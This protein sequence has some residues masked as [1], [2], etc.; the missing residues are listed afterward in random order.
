MA[1]IKPTLPTL[2]ELHHDVKEAFKNDKLNLLLNQPPHE[3]WIKE[4]PIL[5]AK[6]DKGEDVKWRYIPVDKIEFMLTRIFGM[7]QREILTTGIMFNSV[8]ATVRLWVKNP[9][10]GEMRFHDGGGACPIQTDK[11]F[12]AADLSHIK[13]G[14]VQ[15]ALPAAI[16]YALKD[17]AENY[18]KLFGRDLNKRDT[19]AFSG[20]YTQSA[21]TKEVKDESIYSGPSAVVNEDLPSQTVE[22]EL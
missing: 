5:K 3:K 15:M 13:S 9:I 17:A 7:W 19:I 16:S 10:T 1:N 20:A 8:Y 21:E 4:H 6:N 18:G 11:G 14:A 12:S 22:F 2:A